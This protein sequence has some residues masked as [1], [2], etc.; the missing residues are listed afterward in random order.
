VTILDKSG[1]VVASSAQTLIGQSFAY[2]DYFR[3]PAA[4]PAQDTLYV[5]PPFKGVSGDWLIALSK[6]IFGKMATFLALR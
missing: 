2:R 4:T 1:V 3:T 5:T 6:V